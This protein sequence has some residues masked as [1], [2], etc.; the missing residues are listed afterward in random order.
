MSDDL[1]IVVNPIPMVDAGPDQ[2]VCE[3]LSTIFEASGALSYLWSN[4]VTNGTTLALE[5]GTWSFSVQGTDANGCSDEDEMEII[6]HALPELEVGADI[7]LC[8][9]ELLTLSAVSDGTVGWNSGQPNGTVFSPSIG[10][11]EFI[12]TATS[13]FGCISLDSLLVTVYENP[14]LLVEDVEICFGQM[15][16]LAA[17]GA[18]NY[19]WTGGI[20]NDVGF[21]P[22]QT[23][24]FTV[25]GTDSHGCSATAS[26]TVTVH[27][28]PFVDFQILDPSL[29]TSQST[30]GF[31][32]LSQGATSYYWDFGDGNPG[33]TAF[34]PEHTFPF[35]QS[36]EYAIT[37]TGY[38][39]FGCPAEKVKF[40]HVFPDFTV[41]VPNSFTPDQNGVNEVFKPVLEGFNP[42][43]YTL[44]IFNRWGD[45]IFES[46]DMEVGWDG[47][48]A[49]Q[50]F[51][52]QDNV[53][54]WK[55]IAGLK[56]SADTKIFVGHVALLK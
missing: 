6:V 38:S 8:E 21:Y 56:E 22:D 31:E 53:Y 5:V 36:G 18:E 25:T 34:E 50:N 48:F 3:G 46:H 4:G 27:P 7:S 51:Q 2:A 40:V 55:I 32:N 35:D 28:V 49:G 26:A 30:T 54:V 1:T 16:V 33:S 43:D 17:T 19:S 29:T 11:S 20:L 10:Q 13:N 45:L 39:E 24:T 23:Q 52:V 9:G 12:A 14:Q 42:Q 37:L 41:Y 47:T 44:Y 15:A